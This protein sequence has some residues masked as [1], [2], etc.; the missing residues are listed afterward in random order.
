[1]STDSM[2]ASAR[3]QTWR[4]WIAGLL[5]LAT[6]INYMDRMTLGSA[7]IRVTHEFHLTKAQ[8]GHIEFAFSLAFGLGSVVFGFLADRVRVYL[9]YPAVLAAWSAVG[10]ATGLTEG[11]GGLLLCRG[12]L[13]FFEAGHWPCAL[14][15]TFAVMSEKDRTMGNSILQSGASIGAIVT[16]QIMKAIMTDQPGS[17]RPGFLAIGV[18]GLVWVGLWFIS[19][20]ARDLQSPAK[21]PSQ[22]DL[23]GLWAILRGS[24]FW[25][26]AL[27]VLGIHLTWH[28]LR[29]WLTL[30]LREGRGY[31]ETAALDFNSAFF[32]AADVGCLLTGV[33][34]AWLVRR[35]HDPHHARRRVF[36][37]GCL[38]TSLS[39]F[40]PILPQGGML[41]AVLLLM[42]A[43]AL[44]LFPCYYSFTQ[45]L[46]ATHLGRITGLLALWVW[47]AG[48]P[49]HS[50]VG[51]VID[52]T[53]SYDGILALAGLTPWL[54]VLAMKFLWREP[55]RKQPSR[56]A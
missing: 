52:H 43:G 31:T 2:P 6:M 29:V 55:A 14:K 47:W 30:F 20:R 10:F 4:W 33:T 16:P 39:V 22:T 49:F 35:G 23:S 34:A 36:F 27:L 51:Y 3:S 25:A 19:L 8:Y 15:T 13:G 9:L 21:T 38:F 37:G 28:I 40:I 26:V 44:A 56:S 24:S 17:W 53:R 48:A 45:E 11:F 50:L 5:L 42:A 32:I 41:L 1:M 18:A 46:S 54:G 7:S 12:L